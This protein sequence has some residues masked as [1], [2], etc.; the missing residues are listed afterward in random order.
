MPRL[1]SVGR[2][3]EDPRTRAAVLES[4]AIRRE[5]LKRCYKIPG[6]VRLSRVEKN[7]VYDEVREQVKREK[8]VE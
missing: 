4:D 5:T 7:K 1:Y 6:Y 8:A 3:A 2:F